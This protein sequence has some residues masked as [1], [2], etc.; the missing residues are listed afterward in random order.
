V[1]SRSIARSGKQVTDA[2]MRFWKLPWA[3]AERA[4]HSDGFVASTAEPATS[5]AWQRI[6]QVTIAELQPFARDLRQTLAA[7]ARAPGSPRPRRCWSAAGRGCAA[8]PR[9]SPRARDPD[10]AADR[11]RHRRARRAAAGR[12]GRSHVAIDTRR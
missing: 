3:D 12:R 7:C 6:L 1:F 2:I 8:S 4:K 5:E 11:R 9:S 10:L